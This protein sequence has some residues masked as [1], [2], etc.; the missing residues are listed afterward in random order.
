L[1][2]VTTN[3]VS[4][5]VTLPKHAP[6]CK[7]KG[8]CS[9]PRTC[10]CARL[11]GS[12][13]PYESFKDGGRL[14]ETKDIV[15]E[16]GPNCGCRAACV[17][18]ASQGGLKYNLEV[19]RT[20]NKGWG[21]RSRDFIPIGAFVCEYIG[22]IK[23]SDKA[24]DPKNF[25]IMD[26]DCL[27]TMKGLGGR[28]KRFADVDIS[29]SVL[30]DKEDDKVEFCIDSRTTGNITRYI[31]HSCAPNLYV[32]CVLSDHHDPRLAR[33]VLFATDN[34]APYQELSYDYG[35]RANSVVHKNGKLYKK[36]MRCSCDA[37][38]CKEFMC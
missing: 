4:S 24:R 10:A 26:I 38:D 18:R 7:C 28:E 34:I 6:G 36:H 23:R 33:I 5:S 29:A 17:N 22:E 1:T 19:F 27:Q 15:Y 16:C 13:F 8:A 35:Y 21:V 32:Q 2:Y 3:K 30:L 25:Y 20:P 14:T 31:N 11:N 37:P 9:D 12:D